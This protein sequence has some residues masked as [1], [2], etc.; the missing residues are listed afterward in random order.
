MSP[1]EI[2]GPPIWTL[3]HTLSEKINPH[4]YPL[5]INSMFGII[6]K[7]CNFL[8]CP[9]CSKDASNFLGKTKSSEYKT[10]NDFKNMLYLFHNYVN[11]KKH[12]PLFNYG[13]I[14]KYSNFNLEIVIKN[15]IANYNTKGNMKL[16]SESFQRTLV[17]K[18]F[19]K[20]IKNY[21]RAFIQP[22]I[23]NNPQ[24]QTI[25]PIEKKLSVIQAEDNV[26][27]NTDYEEQT[28]YKEQSDC[29]KQSNYKEQSELEE[30][31]QSDCEEQ[32]QFIIE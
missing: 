6:V 27:Q 21:S 1:P 4:L 16:L 8:P 30:Q 12:K 9:E 7:I 24:I 10:K 32:E 31:E 29:E 25:Q 22:M 19:I 15:F 2:W 3:F 20:W 23:I 18:D 17:I 5:V 28:N 13:Y 11:K 14:N 26:K